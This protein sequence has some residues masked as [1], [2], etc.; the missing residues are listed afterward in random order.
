VANNRLL[1]PCSYELSPI[2]SIG[3]GYL[4]DNRDL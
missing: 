2:I 3:V 4:Q 1:F